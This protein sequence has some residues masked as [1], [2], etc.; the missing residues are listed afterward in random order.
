M[1]QNERI[2]GFI[3]T[4]EGNSQT[5]IA[6]IVISSTTVGVGILSTIVAIVG[7]SMVGKLAKNFEEVFTLLFIRK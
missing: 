4:A 7:F 5:Y 3:P 1:V 2:P 6:K